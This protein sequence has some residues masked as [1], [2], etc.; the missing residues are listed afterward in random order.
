MARGKWNDFTSKY[1]FHEGADLE[2]VDWR[3][4]DILVGLLNERTEMKAAGVR[5][6][7]YDRPGLHN[8]C[9]IVLLQDVAGQTDAEL[10]ADWLRDIHAPA[11]Q[12]DFDVDIDS[13]VNEAYDAAK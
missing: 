8:G 11:A 9:L 2:D 1:G 6:I 7:P 12:P 3:A 10:W 5:A 4:R 13:L